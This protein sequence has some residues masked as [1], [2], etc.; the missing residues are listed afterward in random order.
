VIA[1]DCATP[2]TVYAKVALFPSPKVKVAVP[3]GVAT[4]LFG[5]NGKALNGDP[6][7]R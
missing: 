4:T 1:F 5:L 7:V 6:V 3:A 2:S